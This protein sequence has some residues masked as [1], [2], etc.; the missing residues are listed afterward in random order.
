MSK[1]IRYPDYTLY[2]TTLE[3]DEMIILTTFIVNIIFKGQ[4][5][6]SKNWHEL[7]IEPPR[8]NLARLYW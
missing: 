8:E 6:S 5:G 3:H 4:Y 1:V 7:K 2:L